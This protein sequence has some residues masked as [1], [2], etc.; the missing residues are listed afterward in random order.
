[1][2]TDDD[3]ID[4][5]HATLLER[6]LVLTIDFLKHFIAVKCSSKLGAEQEGSRVFPKN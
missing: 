4:L 2:I 6:K 1:M 5:H 3:D